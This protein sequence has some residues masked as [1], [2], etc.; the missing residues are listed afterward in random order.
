M[1]MMKK[2]EILNLKQLDHIHSELGILSEIKHD[3]IVNLI[4]ISQDPGYLYYLLEYIPGGELFTILRTQGNF[5][6]T[7]AR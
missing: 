2:K 5:S 1:K 6:S 4:G 7:Q 3:F